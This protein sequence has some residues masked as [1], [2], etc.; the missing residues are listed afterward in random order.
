MNIYDFSVENIDGDFVSLRKYEGKVILNLK[1][2]IRA[3]RMSRASNGT[4]RS[5]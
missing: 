5:F 1:E 4:L 2:K 3:I